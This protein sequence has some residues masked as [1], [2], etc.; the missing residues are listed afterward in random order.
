MVHQGPAN[1][2]SPLK[3]GESSEKS[4]GENR[5]KSC[6]VC[7]CHDFFGP[8]SVEDGFKHW[9][10]W[11][12]GAHWVPGSELSEFLSAYYWCAKA[13]SPSFSQNPPSLPQNSVSSFFRNSTLET[14]FRPFP[15][16][17]LEIKG[18]TKRATLEHPF[19]SKK[20][21]RGIIMA[22]PVLLPSQGRKRN[23]NPNFLVQAS[24]G[25]AGVFQ[26]KGW[27]P[28]SSVCPSKP[29]QTKLFGGIS[30]DSCRVFRGCPT[31]LRK[32]V[33]VWFLSPKRSPYKLEPRYRR[34]KLARKMFIELRVLYVKNLYRNCETKSCLS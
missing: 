22:S 21:L 15:T 9:T 31:S 29:W 30:R 16:F 25:R 1:Q 13:N 14:V 11:V 4:S 33:C 10:Q 8:V 27:G 5:V 6:H 17:L 18:K 32:K 24:S 19:A 23:P 20:V 28:K 12:F 7:G 26:V 3:S 2:T 34:M